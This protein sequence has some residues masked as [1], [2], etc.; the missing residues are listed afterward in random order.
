LK[1]EFEK[2]QVKMIGLVGDHTIP[3]RAFCTCGE[4]QKRLTK[5]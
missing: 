1:D 2:R 3:K 5:R 4:I